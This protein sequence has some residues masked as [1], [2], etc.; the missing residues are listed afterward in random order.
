MVRDPD[1][2]VWI[3]AASVGHG[4]HDDVIFLTR[5]RLV[6][7][8][9]LALSWTVEPLDA[10]DRPAQPQPEEVSAYARCGTPNCCYCGTG[11][12]NAEQP[13]RESQMVI[14][15]RAPDGAPT[16]WCDPEIADLVTVLNA[17]GLPTVASCSG[18]GHRPGRISLG[19]GRELFVLDSA[20]AAALDR[21]FPIDINGNYGSA[22]GDV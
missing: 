3:V 8:R 17:G 12:G 20:G 21:F 2:L 14:V 1:G 7:L 16:V 22:A 4:A 10:R 19:D 9:H 15:A 18:H 11:T 13:T 5:T 6:P